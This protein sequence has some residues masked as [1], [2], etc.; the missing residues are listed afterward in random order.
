MVGG[1]QKAPL[2][3]GRRGSR[4]DGRSGRQPIGNIGIFLLNLQVPSD[5]I[6][7]SGCWQCMQRRFTPRESRRRD[8]HA[9]VSTEERSDEWRDL[10]SGVDGLHR[11]DKVSPL[12]AFGA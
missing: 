8:L 2:G 3:L 10:A 1:Q 12:R 5:H 4:R 7:G 11:G 9:V 6:F